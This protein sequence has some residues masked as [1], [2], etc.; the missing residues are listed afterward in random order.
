MTL[1]SDLLSRLDIS[2]RIG[3]LSTTLDDHRG[4]GD[5]GVGGLLPVDLWIPGCPPHP[6][7]IVDGIVRLLGRL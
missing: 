1:S 4:S 2:A 3:T 6:W 5:D 7:T